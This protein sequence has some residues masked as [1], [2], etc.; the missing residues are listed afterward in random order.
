MDLINALVGS[1][2]YTHVIF[3]FFLSKDCVMH[4]QP[5]DLDPKK[6]WIMG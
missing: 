6:S 2:H 5:S 3:F 1:P 4:V